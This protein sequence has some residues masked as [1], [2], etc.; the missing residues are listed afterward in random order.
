MKLSNFPIKGQNED[1][2]FNL[3]DFFTTMSLDKVQLEES[4]NKSWDSVKQLRML[5]NAF[6]ET[7]MYQRMYAELKNFYT[8]KIIQHP[9]TVSAIQEWMMGIQ[10]DMM[11]ETP[12]SDKKGATFGADFSKTICSDCGQKGHRHKGFKHCPKH[13][14]GKADA[15]STEAGNKHTKKSNSKRE[16]GKDAETEVYGLDAAKWMEH[17]KAHASQF[18]YM[19]ETGKC[20]GCGKEGVNYSKCTNPKCQAL[21]KKHRALL[22]GDTPSVNANESEVI[23]KPTK[24]TK[25]LRFGPGM[26]M[27]CV[28]EEKATMLSVENFVNN[29]LKLDSCSNRDLSPYITDFVH[30]RRLKPHE[31]ENVQGVWGQ[32]ESPQYI[33]TTVYWT[34][35]TEGIIRPLRKSNVLFDPRSNARLASGRRMV[36]DGVKIDLYD[37]EIATFTMADGGT[38]DVDI[39]NVNDLSQIILSSPPE[40]HA[41]EHLTHIVGDEKSDE[42]DPCNGPESHVTANVEDEDTQLET[43]ADALYGYETFHGFPQ[44]SATLDD[45]ISSSAGLEGW[46]NYGNELIQE[47][48]THSMARTIAQV[49]MVH[50][51]IS[52]KSLMHHRLM[53]TGEANM[54]DTKKHPR[55]GGVR[56]TAKD[57][58]STCQSCPSGKAKSTKQ[59]K[60]VLMPVRPVIGDRFFS[61]TSGKLRVKSLANAQYTHLMSD[62]HSRMNWAVGLVQKSDVTPVI[63][64]WLSNV[65]TGEHIDFRVK[66]M[67]TDG[68]RSNYATPKFTAMLAKHGVKHLKIPEYNPSSAGRI[69]RAQGVV[70]AMAQ[71]ALSYSGHGYAYYVMA[72]IHAAEVK[73]LLAHSSLDG[74]IPMSRWTSRDFSHLYRFLRVWGCPAFVARTPNQRIKHQTKCWEG[75]YVGIGSNGYTFKIYDPLRN[76]VVDRRNVTFDEGW[77]ED[78]N[79][80]ASIPRLMHDSNFEADGSDEEVLET[81]HDGEL[82]HTGLFN[83]ELPSI[84]EGVSDVHTLSPVSEMP[85]PFLTLSEDESGSGESQHGDDDDTDSDDEIPELVSD[86]EDDESEDEEEG[87]PPSEKQEEPGLQRAQR[88]SRNPQPSYVHTAAAKKPKQKWLSPL[89][90]T[91]PET[92][93]PMQGVSGLTD[94]EDDDTVIKEL[95]GTAQVNACVVTPQT[96]VHP[97]MAQMMANTVQTEAA[98]EAHVFKHMNIPTPKS[99]KSA[100]RIDEEHDYPFKW[101]SSMEREYNTL[102]KRGTWK[103]VSKR[104]VPSGKKCIPSIWQFKVKYKDGKLVE[105]K[106][107]GCAGG[108]RQ[109]QGVD[110]NENYSPTTRISN[111]RT[112]L[113]ATIED[114]MDSIQDDIEGAFLYGRMPDQYEVYML[115]FEGFET[116]D[117]HGDL[118]VYL[119]VMGLYGLVQ[120][121]LLFNNELVEFFQAQGFYQCLTDPC[122]FVKKNE[123]EHII[124]PVHVDDMIPTGKPAQALY[125]FED[126]LGNTFDIKRLGPVDWFSGILIKREKDTISLSQMAYATDLTRKFGMEN[127]NPT[128]VPLQHGLDLYAMSQQYDKSQPFHDSTEVRAFVGSYAWLADCTRPDLMFTRGHFAR[129][130]AACPPEA[131]KHMKNSLRYLYATK[132][133]GIQYHKGTKHRY[134]LICFVDASF[135]TCPVTGRSV[136]CF[137]MFLHGGPIA[138]K[139]KILPGRP[140][141][142][143]LDAEYAAMYHAHNELL[144]F[145]QLLEEMGFP[146]NGPCIMYCDNSAAQQLAETGRLT[147]ANRHTN[148]KYHAIRWSILHKTIEIQHVPSKNN[149][150]DIGTKLFANVQL[151]LKYVKYITRNLH[152][153]VT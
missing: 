8:R 125:D 102:V 27:A 144:Y 78:R 39:H 62:C 133:I 18:P 80:L 61:D 136:F 140:S 145:R 26:Q 153:E 74:D 104:N 70:D 72:Y 3:S 105:F 107:R 108:H 135:A 43:D 95:L 35:D 79:R 58:L 94:D 124:V 98:H 69:E 60:A 91:I 139:S 10:K 47:S 114:E 56:W 22:R 109:I 137:I 111:V 123:N 24:R 44:G 71:A 59:S 36:R 122:M 7:P 85:N 129:L 48:S 54:E 106:A 96:V 23:S 81:Q 88:T 150:A 128:L 68:D 29:L 4:G 152:S 151:F 28:V 130:Q 86:S 53:H 149:L 34:A 118:E 49:S 120:A 89:W 99:R 132:D 138:W 116:Y 21:N 46:S 73:N 126:A 45:I 67:L 15:N 9:M 110:Y 25:S 16:S 143:T 30:I 14:K 117:E 1:G 6:K 66:E 11:P 100:L 134:Q 63:D 13:A 55:Y 103:K 31:I 41:H 38:F 5:D 119:L 64:A 12:T 97:T 19:K 42:E 84:E 52:R 82:K 83:H 141:G 57:P 37:K 115:P 113:A 90:H 51:T 146:H 20:W 2:F 87:P 40:E 50:P 32:A 142:S 112:M 127:S 147:Q 101:E 92:S 77:I 17:H 131:F 75:V 93:S 148:V 121:A 65:S 33:G 76:K